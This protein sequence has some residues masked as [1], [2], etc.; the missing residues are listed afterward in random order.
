M[1]ELSYTTKR[2]IVGIG[3]GLL[4]FSIANYFI[5]FGILAQFR[6]EIITLVFVVVV[7]V[8]NYFGPTLQEVREHRD[9][10]RKP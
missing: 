6:K 2:V 8:V 1:P 7:L 3:F 5:G 4:I 10:A 9:N